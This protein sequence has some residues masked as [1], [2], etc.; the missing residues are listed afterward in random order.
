MPNP[1]PLFHNGH[2][3]R[4]GQKVLNN[5]ATEYEMLEY[6]L[7]KAVPRRDMRPLARLLMKTFGSYSQVITAP[8]DRLLEV[9][10]VGPKIIEILEALRQSSEIDCRERIA[11]LPIFDNPTVLAN[12]CKMM[13]CGAPVEEFHV[14]YLDARYR[15]IEDQMHSKGDDNST[16]VYPSI[17]LGRAMHLRAKHVFLYHNHPSETARFSSPDIECT[18]R[19]IDKLAS[20]GIALYDH[21]LIAGATVH[22]ML[23]EGW[24]RRSNVTNPPHSEQN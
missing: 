1:D 19:I 20:E 4:L 10:G 6:W 7:T 21:Y 2:R 5:K 17:I 22:S 15:M 11:S 13:V 3:Q 9:K 12:Y 16:E 18:Q 23:E 14:I 8:R 24:L